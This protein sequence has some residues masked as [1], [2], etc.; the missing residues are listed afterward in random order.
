M[1]KYFQNGVCINRALDHARAHGD[2]AVLCIMDKL[3]SY[4]RY[5]EREYGL[6]V[7]RKTIRRSAERRTRSA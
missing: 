7:L 5:V 2:T 1:K 3:P 4:I 6:K